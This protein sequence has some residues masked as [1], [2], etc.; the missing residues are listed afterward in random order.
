MDWIGAVL[1]V[2]VVVVVGPVSLMF[3]GAVWSAA[4]GFFASEDADDRY[5]DSEYVKNDLW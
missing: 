5:A 3:A 2:L 1:V 4:I